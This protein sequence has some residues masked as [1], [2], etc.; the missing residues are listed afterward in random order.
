MDIPDTSLQTPP[1]SQCQL[2]HSS[3]LHLTLSP[4][5]CLQK[6]P[7]RDEASD[8][9]LTMLVSEVGRCPAGGPQGSAAALSS[10][11][12]TA[13]APTHCGGET[14]RSCCSPA[15]GA[16]RHEEHQPPRHLPGALLPSKA[17]R[18]LGARATRALPT[19]PPPRGMWLG[20][21][22]GLHLPEPTVEQPQGPNGAERYCHNQR[23]ANPAEY[24]EGGLASRS[25]WDSCSNQS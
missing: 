13:M 15:P 8:S 1:L 25:S 23:E 7:F 5:A 12:R 6:Q 3:V 11:D 17:R 14:S 9:Q 22:E 24:L 20:A 21:G 2:C 4:P 19:P 18:A 16:S 10:W